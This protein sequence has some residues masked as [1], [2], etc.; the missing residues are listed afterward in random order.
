MHGRE[1][2]DLSL[3]SAK[4]TVTDVIVIGGG[5]S[6]LAA[7]IEAASL[8][9]SVVVLEKNPKIGG[10][11]VRSIGSFSASGSPYQIRKGIKDNPDDHFADLGKFNESLIRKFP[12]HHTVDNLEL[13]RIITHNS[14]ETLRWL[15]SMGLRFYG[16]TPEPPHRRPR[17]HNVLP[18]SQAYGYFLARRARALNVDVRTSRR[19]CKFIV[20]EGRV[21][22]VECIASD[23]RIERYKALGGVVL[24][25]GDF[26]ASE[27]MK[28]KF[29]SDREARIGPSCNPANT[30]D[31]HAMA[32]ELGAQVVNP[33]LV[34]A[35]IRFVPP[36]KRNWIQR[37]PPWRILTKFIEL[38][39]EYMPQRLL[40]PFIM[41]FL[42]TVLAASPRLFIAGAI[43]VN[44]QGERFC[45]ELHEPVYAIAEQPEQKAFII[46]DHKLAMAF[47][48]YPNFV[49]TAPGIAYAY[50]PDYE[51]S[52]P[53]IFNKASTLAE[54]A[55]R[56]GA[57]PA[58]L[59]KA[60][61]DGNATVSR[62]G[63]AAAET[64]FPLP[65]IEPPFY[66]L[67]PIRSYVKGTDAGLAIN[68]QFQVL[69][70]GGNPIPGL[71][72]AGLAGQ[73]GVL[74]EGHGHHLCWAFTSGR[75]A[76]RNAAYLATSAALAD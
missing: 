16:P 55:R 45:D 19:A 74:L 62:D 33:H 52:R 64:G 41:S 18:N 48:K 70:D 9:R 34:M 30:G 12:N 65:I 39:L 26:S 49:S 56:I 24:A 21:R 36:S 72:A 27:E 61:A 50:V 3:S 71:F 22:G 2:S 13:R 29:G 11:T 73:G 31:G 5:G 14:A 1:L 51:R 57:N 69:G 53:D 23:G 10:S 76:G 6:G 17:M 40:R 58:A 28:R 44:K 7:A 46:F 63:I 25:C 59:E 15:M 42:T 8:G 4:E 38:S 35:L 68:S 60:V 32:M 37:L 43:L 67:G 75:L 47:S 20:E 66:A 54:L